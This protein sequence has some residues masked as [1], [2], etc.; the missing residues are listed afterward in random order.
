MELGADDYL[1]K[2][3]SP[4]ELISAIRTRLNRAEQARQRTLAFATQLHH[5]LVYMLPHELR[6]PLVTILGFSE[7]LAINPATLNAQEITDIAQNIL[8]SG[9]RLQNLIENFLLY[10]QLDQHTTNSESNQL[11]ET[12]SLYAP[13]YLIARLAN[14][15]ANTRNRRDDLQLDLSA[16]SPLHIAEADLSKIVSELIKNAFEFSKPGTPVVITSRIN[17][18][19]YELTI[20]DRGRGMKPDEVKRIGALIQF[21]RAIYE[22]QGSGLGLILAKRL[23]D[24]HN[25]IFT[26]NSQVGI[27]TTITIEIPLLQP[28]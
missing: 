11:T 13:D 21:N 16:N 28:F 3:F 15:I 23:V 24:L 19:C 22:Q 9:Y 2:P 5:E 6:T 12:V 20:I 17:G 14:Q 25:G 8:S 1:T 7:L 18:P 26:M 4:T 10:V 27:G